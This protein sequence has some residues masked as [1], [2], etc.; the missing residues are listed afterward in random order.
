MSGAPTI[1]EL[2]PMGIGVI[3]DAA[4]RLY[5]ARFITFL[6]IALVAYLPYAVYELAIGLAFGAPDA[7]AAPMVEGMGGDAS[8]AFYAAE[9]TSPAQT[10]LTTLGNLLFL[11]FVL[12]LTQA[13]LTFNISGAVLGE[14][15]TAGQSYGRAAGRLVPLLGTQML[16]GMAVMLGFLLL[17]VPGIIFSLWFMLVA[18]VVVLERMAGATAMGRSKELMKG[19]LGKG[20]GLSFLVGLLSMVVNI[21]VGFVLGMLLPRHPL[22]LEVG[23][24]VAQAIILP[25]L[26]APMILLYYDL[27]VRKEAFDLQRLADSVAGPAGAPVV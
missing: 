13:A 15:L 18:P 3:L 17:I 1:V 9:A 24:L 5:K 26:T 23:L 10:L 19:N 4:F 20:F 25:L 16:V 14:R 2:R 22:V 6:V 27:R 12:P 7:A 11:F 8:Q 21:G